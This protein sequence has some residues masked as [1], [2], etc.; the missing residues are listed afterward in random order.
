ML[1]YVLT[2][3][4]SDYEECLVKINLH[5]LRRIFGEIPYRVSVKRQLVLEKKNRY[6]PARNSPRLQI[7]LWSLDRVS[8]IELK[9]VKPWIVYQG[10]R[11]KRHDSEIHL[12]WTPDEGLWIEGAQTGRR[13]R[14]MPR[15]VAAVLC[16]VLILTY[17]EILQIILEHAE[18]TE[19]F[20][21]AY[22]I[23]AGA[24]F[25][26]AGLIAFYMWLG[27]RSGPSGLEYVLRQFSKVFGESKKVLE[28]EAGSNQVEKPANEILDE[29]K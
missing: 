3:T 29:R 16:G 15:L 5:P 7:E 12:R 19:K 11:L 25:V 28:T 20:A 2:S 14:P 18:K 21:L 6:R 24:T 27:F 8:R 4:N 1:R 22:T 9:L 17:P 23:L 26:L 13:T 10:P